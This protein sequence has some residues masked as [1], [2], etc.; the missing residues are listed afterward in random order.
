MKEEYEAQRARRKMW[1]DFFERRC[2]TK[3]D[4]IT[5]AVGALVLREAECADLRAR[6]R[7]LTREIDLLKQPLNEKTDAQI[8]RECLYLQR[9]K[10]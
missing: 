4:V 3:R 8:I 2:P 10:Q 1:E 5:S 7:E 9:R 6:V